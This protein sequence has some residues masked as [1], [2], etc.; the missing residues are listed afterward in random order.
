LVN[1]ELSKLL[2]LFILR[3]AELVESRF[4]VDET[5]GEHLLTNNEF[6]IQF[7]KE[8][9]KDVPASSLHNWMS[10]END[11]FLACLE[12]LALKCHHGAFLLPGL[13]V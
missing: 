1:Y 11:P 9:A 4:V 12:V 2:L 5:W 3:M 6:V 8:N 13:F 10:Y 7:E